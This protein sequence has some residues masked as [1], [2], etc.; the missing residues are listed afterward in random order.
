M[1]ALRCSFVSLFAAL[2]CA[3]ALI[4]GEPQPKVD[5]KL[6]APWPNLAD[7][8]AQAAADAKLPQDNDFIVHE[9]GT[10]T[11]FSGSDGVALDFRPLVDEDLP[12]FVM[13]RQKQASWSSERDKAYATGRSVKG[14]VISR[15][16]METP[17]TYFYTERERIVDVRVEF[18]HGLLTEFYPPVR[19]FGPAF[20][21]G[22]P[23]VLENSFLRWG[24]VRLIPASEATAR[25][26]VD[27]MIRKIDKGQGGEHYGYAR[28]TDSA[29]VQ[30]SDAAMM[31][32]FREKFLFYRGVGNFELPVTLTSHG[33]D[34][35]TLA[36]SGKTPL[37][38]AF[39]VASDGRKFRFA[40][41]DGLGATTEMALPDANATTAE[42]SA[43]MVAALISDGLFEKEA[44]AMVKTWQASWFT[45]EGTRVLYALPQSCTDALLPLRITPAPKET[46]RVMI[47]RLE[48]LTP[49]R[50]KQ[51]EALAARL[52]DD[53]P[54]VRDS[55]SAGI[56]KLGRFAEPTLTRLAR[57]ST[58]PEASARAQSLLK[59]LLL[60]KQ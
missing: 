22:Q 39:L 31:Q 11:S 46:I 19:E 26:G 33:A 21:K 13:D 9:W 6:A 7:A 25:T 34:R 5:P 41:Y 15:Q 1:R 60:D 56:R 12:A 45:E 30:L 29:H 54:A 2:A 8:A 38:Y 23:E 47:G 37:H 16:R 55:A 4:A 17:V 44:K 59:Q 53:D 18:P 51:V 40:K 3:A 28:E 32:T 14:L 57:T 52:G 58:D 49:E 24:K 43:A 27:P 10:F 20:K 42:L 48:T 35:F 36:N 50:E